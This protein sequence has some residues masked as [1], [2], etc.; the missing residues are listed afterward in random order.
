MR[1]PESRALDNYH[2]DSSIRLS[3][4]SFASLARRIQPTLLTILTDAIAVP[5]VTFPPMSMM[6]PTRLE[7]LNMRGW[8]PGRC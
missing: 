2:R 5:S 8:I 7:L 6:A 3:S 4:R 1:L